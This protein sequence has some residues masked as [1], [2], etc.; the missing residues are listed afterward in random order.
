MV[1][2]NGDV[3]WIKRVVREAQRVVREIKPIV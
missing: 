3:K 1:R 2:I